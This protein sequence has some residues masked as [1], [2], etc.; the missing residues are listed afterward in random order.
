MEI[1]F[2]FLDRFIFPE[3]TF[4]VIVLTETFKRAGSGKIIAHKY[5]TLIIGAVL[6]VA[7]VLMKYIDPMGMNLMKLVTSFALANML[8]TYVIQFIKARFPRKIDGRQE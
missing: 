2:L 7:A 6:A 4:A 3:Y 1:I 5:T 8:Y